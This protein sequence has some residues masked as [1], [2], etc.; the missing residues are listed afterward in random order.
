M[1][2]TKGGIKRQKW[3]EK[4]SLMKENKIFKTEF[5]FLDILNRKRKEGRKKEMEGKRE[6]GR[7][8]ILPP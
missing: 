6:G 4:I 5:P 8:K 2:R 7:R 3:R 1:E